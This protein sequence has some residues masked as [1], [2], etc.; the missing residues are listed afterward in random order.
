M[1]GATFLRLATILWPVT[2]PN[3]HRAV[4]RPRHVAAVGAWADAGVLD[5]VDGVDGTDH[6]VRTYAYVCMKACAGGGGGGGR[7]GREVARWRCTTGRVGGGRV[8][9]AR[10]E[11]GS[12]GGGR[13]RGVEV[14]AV[15]GCWWRVSGEGV[16]RWAR[17]GGDLEVGY[18]WFADVVVSY[19][20][21]R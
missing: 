11:R 18:W 1:H 3:G 10:W 14:V 15:G 5:S 13:S 16:G 17:C 8:R 21:L 7:G 20:I 2:L 12:V 4:R 6:V 19:S 9:R